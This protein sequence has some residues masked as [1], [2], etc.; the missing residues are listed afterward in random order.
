MKQFKLLVAALGF[1]ACTSVYAQPIPLPAIGQ[2][3]D[4]NLDR[5]VDANGR[6]KTSGS[7]AVGDTLWAVVTFDKV[8]NS[9]NS[10]FF[11][12]PAPLSGGIELTGISAL[13]I[14]SIVGGV[15]TFGPNAAFEA[16]YGAG[17]LAAL[18]TQTPGNFTV[19]CANVATCESTASDGALWATFGLAD[20]DDFWV[21]SGVLGF[22]IGTDLSVI[23]ATNSATKVAV[24]N[25]AVSV[26]TNN[27]GYIFLDQ[28]SPLSALFAPGGGA[29]QQTK[30]VG[31]GDILGGAG[32]TNGY[33]AR[34]DFDFTFQRAVPEPSVLALMGLGL[35]AMGFRRRK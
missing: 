35:V 27:T 31:S 34:S 32:L 3:E 29:N 11:D 12:I 7:L 24:A 2:L 16:T 4:D 30:I 28:A 17:A 26:L 10:T 9:D 20:A 13:E 5:V 19:G 22:P 25:Y 8:L 14:K 21:A 23:A 33:L 6:V 15:A 1:A 18:Y